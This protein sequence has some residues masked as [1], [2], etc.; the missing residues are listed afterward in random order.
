MPSGG[1]GGGAGEPADVVGAAEVEA[2]ANRLAALRET[3]ANRP[4]QFGPMGST[5]WNTQMVDSNTGRPIEQMADGSW[6]FQETPGG[7]SDPSA[8]PQGRPP[9]P[10]WPQPP[11]DNSAA[12]QARYDQDVQSFNEWHELYGVG[13]AFNNGM[14]NEATGPLYETPANA[15]T[16]SPLDGNSNITAVNKW[17]SNTELTPEWQESLDGGRE[18]LNGEMQYR[19]NQ[20]QRWDANPV[21]YSDIGGS[22]LEGTIRRSDL[23]QFGSTAPTTGSEDWREFGSTAQTTGAQDWRQ[24]G[25]TDQTIQANQWQDIGMA[26]PTLGAND[27]QQFGVTDPTIGANDYQQFGVSAPQISGDDWRQFGN[28]ETNLNSGTY[29]ERY[30]AANADPTGGYGAHGQD[31]ANWDQIQ[32]SP[33]AIRR[34]AEQETLSFMNSQLDPQWDTRQS[35]L[36]SQLSNQGLQWGDAAYD[37]AMESMK[38]SRDQAYSG[39]RNQALADSRSEANMLWGQEMSRSEQKNMQTQADIDNIY[40]A[41]QANIGNHMQGQ[42][43]EQQNYLAYQNA[44]FGQDLNSR[45]QQLDANLNYGREGFQ[46]DFNSRQQQLDAD[47]GYGREAFSQ[48]F[49]SRQQQL[50]ADRGYGNDAFRQDLQS[51]QQGLDAQLNYGRESYQ[52]DYSTRQQNLDSNR[53]YNQQAYNQ[54]YQTRQQDVD[55]NR[56]YDQQAYDQDYQTRQTKISNFLNFGS[57]EH[58]QNLS[59]QQLD[60]QARQAQD[61]QLLDQYNAANPNTTANTINTMMNS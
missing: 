40:R 8:A 41:R 56:L 45:Q 50:D 49:Q 15:G 27:Y 22:N 19:G 14:S 17:T 29:D 37:N 24:F 30:G 4:D 43:Q 59:A 28:T 3:Q 7:G 12:E 1:S 42:G 25:N 11:A 36:E 9:I 32:Y 6:V 48:D 54:D 51:K 52:Q 38:N 31:G 35:D 10:D 44:A 18:L 57:E 13:T 39:A 55:N 58:G 61:Q 33:D 53:L 26:S 5:T 23:D 47:L 2:E 16:G 21:D 34:Q 20:L 60:L 46:Q